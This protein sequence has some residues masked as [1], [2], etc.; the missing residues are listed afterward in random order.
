MIAKHDQYG[1]MLWCLL[2]E[3]AYDTVTF[4]D[5]M[6]RDINGEAGVI[7]LT[8]ARPTAGLAQ[9]EGNRVYFAGPGEA[10]GQYSMGHLE[11]SIDPGDPGIIGTGWGRLSGDPVDNDLKLALASDTPI[12]IQADEFNNLHVPCPPGTIDPITGVEVVDAMRLFGP[13]GAP[14]FRLTARPSGGTSYQNCYAI[15]LPPVNP[16]YHI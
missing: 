11:D 5:L 7:G 16:D 8:K 4:G 14:L 13:D 9:G 6:V 1:N 2:S 12:R 15:G 10:D 3:T